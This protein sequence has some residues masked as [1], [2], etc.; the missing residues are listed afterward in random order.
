M[1][2]LGLLLL[3]VLALELGFALLSLLADASCGQARL[4][5]LKLRTGC[6]LLSLSAALAVQACGGADRP[7]GDTSGDSDVFCYYVVWEIDAL[8]YDY[9]AEAWWYYIA[10]IG[11]SD[12]AT[13]DI[14]WLSGEAVWDERHEL[15]S[16]EKA[17]DG[18]WQV[19]ETTLPIVEDPEAFQ[20]SENTLLPGNAKVEDQVTRMA[21][22]YSYSSLQDCW[23]WGADPS[24]FSDYRCWT[25]EVTPGFAR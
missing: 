25:V 22:L 19:W 14:H 21:S 8:E 24:Y 5:K 1:L 15:Q 16:T 10:Q 11:W 12:L 4:V 3:G 17:L 7:V 23:V 13:M 6:W 18:S 20:E 2:R 9:D